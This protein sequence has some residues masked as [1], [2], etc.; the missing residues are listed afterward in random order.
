[1]TP[2]SRVPVPPH[3]TVLRKLRA[4]WYRAQDA[5]VA[6]ERAGASPYDLAVA[7][8]REQRAWERL[9]E[10]GGIGAQPS[11]ARDTVRAP[12]PEALTVRA[13]ERSE[14]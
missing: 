11:S 5:A 13:P 1:M 6:L 12:E 3:P 4:A 7:R 2:Y 8:D 9:L 10:A 14:A